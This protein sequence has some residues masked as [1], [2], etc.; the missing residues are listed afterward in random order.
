[1]DIKARVRQIGPY[2]G[3]LTVG[4][5]TILMCTT[6]ILTATCTCRVLTP[7]RCCYRTESVTDCWSKFSSYQSL[8]KVTS[9]LSV[10]SRQVCS[11]QTTVI[12]RCARSQQR[13]KRNLTETTFDHGVRATGHGVLT[14]SSSE[15]RTVASAR[16]LTSI[17]R[18]KFLGVSGPLGRS[19][20]G[21]LCW[22]RL[23]QEQPTFGLSF[24]IWELFWQCLLLLVF[25]LT[26]LAGHIIIFLRAPGPLSGGRGRW[27][28]GLHF[29]A[30]WTCC[31]SERCT[32]SLL[33]SSPSVVFSGYAFC[34]ETDLPA[35]TEGE[36]SRGSTALFNF[37]VSFETSCFSS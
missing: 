16:D 31:L 27:P 2:H 23:P 32:S 5:G 13:A 4:S 12:A 21:D 30:V 26:N 34:G 19:C 24:A 10:C 17:Q 8:S 3:V 33:R 9:P 1:M 15:Q 11:Q 22:R 35:T 37:S 20:C 36:S 7:T 29:L 25:F 28:G 6:G 18:Q 14:P